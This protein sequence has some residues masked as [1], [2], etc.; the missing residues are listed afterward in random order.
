[1]V[2]YDC[3]EVDAKL[4]DAWRIIGT[5]AHRLKYLELWYQHRGSSG[6][7]KRGMCCFI[8]EHLEC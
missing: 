7:P 1:M 8:T 3:D 5:L 2:E 4:Q 6:F